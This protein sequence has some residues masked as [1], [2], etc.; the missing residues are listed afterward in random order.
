MSTSL[1]QFVKFSI[2]GGLNTAV[3]FGVYFSLTR[4]VSWF[5]QHLVVAAVLAMA[6]ATVHSYLWNSFWTFQTK[7]TDH[8]VLVSKFLTVSISGFILYT[9]LF[10]SLI[11]FGLSDILVKV[12]LAGF[13]L[14]WNFVGNKWWVY[15]EGYG[16]KSHFR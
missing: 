15:T 10:S 4:W 16:K 1:R 7:R 6:A 14:L 2:V 13:L 8:A 12:L 5:S 11:N 3:D 9:V